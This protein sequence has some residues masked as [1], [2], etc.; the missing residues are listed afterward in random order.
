MDHSFWWD[1]FSERV[2]KIPKRGESCR[3]SSERVHRIEGR[4]IS[5]RDCSQKA[6]DAA[7]AQ[8]QHVVANDYEEQA[9]RLLEVYDQRIAKKIHITY[10][11]Q[12]IK[13]LFFGLVCMIISMIF[14]FVYVHA[15]R[16]VF[17]LV[18]IFLIAALG[19]IGVAGFFIYKKIRILKGRGG[20]SR[21]P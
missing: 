10:D 5:L 11:R 12:S 2:K 8:G 17:P 3:L 14:S 6:I 1:I 7:Y 13:F 18:I 4:Y 16:G 20:L 9:D 19:L 15:A 21:L